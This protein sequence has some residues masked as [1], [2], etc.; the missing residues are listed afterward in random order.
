MLRKTFVVADHQSG[1]LKKDGRVVEVLEPGR[2]VIWDVR[3]CYALEY[4]DARNPVITG[5]WAEALVKR[6]SAIAE[7]YIVVAEP[8]EGE[9]ALVSFDG[10][11]K[12]LLRPGQV[13]Y[14]WTA[15]KAVDVKLMNVRDTA[16]L[17]KDELVAFEKLTILGSTSVSPK[18]IVTLL[19]EATEVGLVYIDGE[20]AETLAPGRYGFWQVGRTVRVEKADKRPQALEVTAQEILTKDRVSIRL[21]LTAFVQVVDAQ[22]AALASANYQEHVYKLVQFATREAVGNRTLDELLTNR[23]VV[24][25]QIVE[26]VRGALGDIGIVVTGLGIKDVILPGE[27]RDLINKVV[28]AEKVAQ[29]NII[30]RREETAATRSL[31]NTARLMEDNPT[32]LR[33][34]ELE[35]LER[36]TEKIGKIDVHASNGQGLNALLDNLVSLKRSGPSN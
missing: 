9:V 25:T 36:V 12:L 34:K 15:L 19:V 10:Q 27:M 35:A 29:A 20:L 1:L 23:D 6:G 17:T 11:P 18:P 16:Q 4:I 2:H 21:T 30:R 26:H 28:E 3:G 14:F 8:G 13:Q 31:L 24:D 32:L 7:K 22:K 5:D 33:L